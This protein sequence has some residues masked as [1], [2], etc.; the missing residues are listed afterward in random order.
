MP[1]AKLVHDLAQT[2]GEIDQ[3]QLDAS[4]PGTLNPS[5]QKPQSA[6]VNP[7]YSAAIYAYMSGAIRCYLLQ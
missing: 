6:R 3:F 5:V 4:E 7:Q 2:F 1:E